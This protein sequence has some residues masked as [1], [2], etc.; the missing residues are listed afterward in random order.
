MKRR[1]NKNCDKE[2]T[3]TQQL[4][5]ENKDL[6]RQLAKLRKE[7]IRS[8]IERADREAVLEDVERLERA[9]QDKRIDKELN[10]KWKCYE[11]AV[12]HLELHLVSRLDGMFYYRACNACK[13]RTKLKKYT[14]DV[15]GFTDE[16]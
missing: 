13:Q 16:S 7:L 4:K 2:F 3:E 8:T 11:C 1:N 12:G 5:T 6:K 10:K 9:S 15:E 14:S